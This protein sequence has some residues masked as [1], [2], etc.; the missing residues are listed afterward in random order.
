MPA[1]ALCSV[2]SV[3]V[4]A[5][6]VCSDLGQIKHCVTLSNSPGVDGHALT[7]NNMV[8]VSKE[9]NKVKI[10]CT[11]PEVCGTILWT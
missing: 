10:T 1:S 3:L 9:S 8:D 6:E 4:Q 2:L 11:I 7:I 5:Q